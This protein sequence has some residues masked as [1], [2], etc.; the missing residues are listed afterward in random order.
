[1]ALTIDDLKPKSF[2]VNV[3]GVELECQ[4]LRLSDA[5]SLAKIGDVFSNSANYGRS[6]FET[7]EADLES[8]V[9][10]L[11]PELAGVKLDINSSLELITQMMQTIEPEDNKEL[12]DKGVSF[13]TDPK[14]GKIG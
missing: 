9:G 3:K 5:L 1:M 7:A 10:K 4:P 6:D 12:K 11:V 13:E 2:K 8:V 14:A